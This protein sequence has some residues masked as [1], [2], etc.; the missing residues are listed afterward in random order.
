MKLIHLRNAV[1]SCEFKNST[2]LALGFFDGVHLGHQQLIMKAKE[3]ST[4]KNLKLAV[5]TFYPH[6]KEVLQGG[7]FNY[8]MTL[9]E[10]EKKMRL[11]GVDY[12]YVVDFNKEFA[13]L[14]PETFVKQYIVDLNAKHVVAGFDYTYGHKGMG[15][16]DTMK[17]Q[18]D[19]KFEVTVLPKVELNGTKVS[20]THIRNL[21]FNGDVKQIKSFMGSMYETEGQL[22]IPYYKNVIM[23]NNNETQAS[24]RNIYTFVPNSHCITPCVGKYLVELQFFNK[25]ESAIAEIFKGINNEKKIT[26]QFCNNSKISYNNRE[27]CI[28]WLDC[29]ESDRKIMKSQ[30]KVLV[31]NR[32][33]LLN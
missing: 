18:G 4:R 21:L 20:S 19:G 3:I 27:L 6:P 8:L 13:G 31:P 16:M 22:Y 28:K 5:M 1:F 26:V 14:S 12:L 9:E 30:I 32:Q 29:L 2:V 23:T 7:K 17:K 15:T 33:S 10:K 11:L 25:K 24:N